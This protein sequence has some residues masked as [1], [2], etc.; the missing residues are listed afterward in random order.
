MT[1]FFE[2]LYGIARYY[3]VVLK[4]IGMTLE[5]SFIGIAAGTFFG[6]V[7]GIGRA[8]SNRWLAF[9]VGAYTDIFRGTPVLVQVFVVFFILPE[10]GI[11]LDS[12]SA[13][14][15]A[16]SNITA[17]FISEIVASGIKAIPAGQ[18][19]AAASAGLTRLQQLRLIVLPQATRMIIPSLVGQFV[20]LVKDSSIVS[21]IGLLDLTRS[22][23]IIVQSVPNGL[24]VFSVVGI[25][26]FL[27]CYPLLY[28]S[29][30][31]ERA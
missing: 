23:W 11:E 7:L 2:Q 24:L 21:A 13:G 9:I 5:L 19:E 25:G 28:L 15:L 17:C 3:P 8:S 29:R 20:L 14:A 4:G 31:L 18:I 16:L 12:F 22:G 10:A 27:I 1:M 6:F 30:R 26:Y